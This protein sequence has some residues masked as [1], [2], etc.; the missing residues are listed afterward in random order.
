MITGGLG[1]QYPWIDSLCIMQKY[2]DNWVIAAG[3]MEDVFSSAYCTIA[4]SSTHSSLEGLFTIGSLDRAL[5]QNQDSTLYLCKPIDNFRCDVEA[6]KE[7]TARPWRNYASLERRLAW[8][9][10]TGADYGILKR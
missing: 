7:L 9:V 5:G 3:N 4:G 6:G 1:I 10:E 2:K 8:A